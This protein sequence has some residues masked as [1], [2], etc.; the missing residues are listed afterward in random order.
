MLLMAAVDLL[1][2]HQVGACRADRLAQLRQDEAAVEQGKAL[3]H[4]EGQHRQAVHGA[5]LVDNAAGGGQGPVHSA[6]WHSPLG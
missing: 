4:V 2:K 1:Q 5:D 3:V 6:P